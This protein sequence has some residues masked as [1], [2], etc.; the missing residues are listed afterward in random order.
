M[1]EE[2]EEKGRKGG[3]LFSTSCILQCAIIDGEFDTEYYA[4]E[5]ACMI[6]LCGELNS[7]SDLH[8]EEADDLSRSLACFL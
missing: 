4:E 7:K 8:A 2:E 6:K 1:Q 3:E 5:R